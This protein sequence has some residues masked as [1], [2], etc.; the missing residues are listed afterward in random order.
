MIGVEKGKVLLSEYQE[1]WKELYKIERD[2]LFTIEDIKEI[3]H[4]GSTSIEK[5][6]AKPIIDIGFIYYKDSDIEKIIKKIE[7]LGYE[8]TE[9]SDVEGRIFF[10]LRE[11]D[12]S[13]YHLSGYE[14]GNIEYEKLI[15]FRDYLNNNEKYREEYAKLKN[16]LYKKY[17][18]DRDKYTLGKTIFI[19]FIIKKAE[20]ENNKNKMVIEENNND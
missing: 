4:I 10:V 15:I 16:D 3:K 8:Y 19:K 2:K 6:I 20:K 18:G 12:K 17:N 14:E 13:L 1:E 11:N 9:N 7:N 5:I